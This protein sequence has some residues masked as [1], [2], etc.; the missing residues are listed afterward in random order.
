MI[1]QANSDH[2]A[3]MFDTKERESRGGK[4]DPRFLFKYEAYWSKDMEAKEI[5]R[6]TWLRGNGNVG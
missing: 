3:V 2:D 5:I 6:N 4:K 1:R